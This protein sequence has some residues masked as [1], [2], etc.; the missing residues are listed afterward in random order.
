MVAPVLAHAPNP[1][2]VTPVHRDE[3][4]YEYDDSLGDR[5]TAWVDRARG[6]PLMWT[7]ALLGILAV[8]TIYLGIALALLVLPPDVTGQP[9][10]KR[11]FTDVTEAAGLKGMSGGTAAWCDYDN[12]GR[13]DL[14]VTNVGSNQLYRNAG[15]GRFTEVPQAGGADPDLWS[16]GCAFLDV[17]RDGDL[18]LF[19]KAP[20]QV[21]I[22]VVTV[23]GGVEID[24]MEIVDTL[25]H[26]V[27]GAADRIVVQ[28]YRVVQSTTGEP[29]RQ[30]TENVHAGIEIHS[31]TLLS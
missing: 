31:P 18:D 7:Y 6:Q 16:T 20:D 8:I 5:V 15:R 29:D 13:I 30:P 10:P 26:P 12:D 4:A 22:A 9:E 28:R 11:N 27:L 2:P 21:A 17:D 1:S 24:D 14:Y 3:A 23:C 25:L 19:D